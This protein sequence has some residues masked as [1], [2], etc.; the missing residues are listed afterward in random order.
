MGLPGDVPMR[1]VAD[2]EL[3]RLRDAAIGVLGDAKGDVY[4]STVARL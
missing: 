2:P 4:A 1:D 3:K